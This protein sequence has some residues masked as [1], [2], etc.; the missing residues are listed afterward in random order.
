[1]GTVLSNWLISPPSP[2]T[3]WIRRSTIN[4]LISSSG[5]FLY[6]SRASSELRVTQGKV[7]TCTGPLSVSMRNHSGALDTWTWDTLNV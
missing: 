7:T 6:S 5:R 2:S 1:V 3:I 4:S